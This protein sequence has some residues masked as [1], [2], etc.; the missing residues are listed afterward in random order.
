VDFRA[1]IRLHVIPASRKDLLKAA[2]DVAFPLADDLRSQ[3]KTSCLLVDASFDGSEPELPKL[4]EDASVR[5]LPVIASAGL[6]VALREL[7]AG[8]GDASQGEWLGLRSTQGAR[9]LALAANRFLYR[10]PYGA[11]GDP[12]RDLAFEELTGD[13]PPLPWGRPGWLLAVFVAAS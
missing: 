13:E 4:A 2:R 8:M 5:S 3:G 12:T 11:K 7:P 6:E 1:G 9:W 10:N